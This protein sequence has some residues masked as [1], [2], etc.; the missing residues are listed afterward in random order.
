MAYDSRD[1]LWNEPLESFKEQPLLPKGHYY[2]TIVR[3]EKNTVGDR[4]TE[5]LDFFCVPKRPAADVDQSALPEFDLNEYE[6]RARFFI[7]KRAMF[8]V[9]NFF[10]SLGQNVALGLDA[11][12]QEAIGAEVL[13][14]V[15]VGTYMRNGQQRTTNNVDEIVG[16]HE[17]PT[18]ISDLSAA[19][20]N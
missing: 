1:S 20:A 19:A 10:S 7:T 8:R 9:R 12:L 6:L 15:T 5:T 18:Q 13:L 4:D 17:V 2:A 11:V 3:F 16:V 14:T